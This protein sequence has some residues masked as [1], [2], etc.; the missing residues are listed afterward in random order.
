[1]HKYISF[2][3]VSIFLIFAAQFLCFAHQAQG[4]QSAGGWTPKAPAKAAAQEAR[5]LN[6]SIIQF[7]ANPAVYHDKY[8]QVT[9]VGNLELEG[10]AVYLGEG[11]WKHRIYK[12]GLWLHLDGG[13]VDY[14]KA[15]AHN[16]KYVYIEGIFDMNNIGHLGLWSG[17][18]RGITRYELVRE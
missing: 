3:S 4:A 6:V 5:P 8:V 13:T 9:G 18:V 1:M 12:N 14:E 7:I 11:D 2:F 10:N 15:K 16:G 17:A